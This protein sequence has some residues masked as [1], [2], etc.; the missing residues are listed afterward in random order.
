[1]ATPKVTVTSYE[2]W[3]S[4]YGFQESPDYNLKAAFEAGLDPEM[5][6]GDGKFHLSDRF[7]LPTHPTY[8]TDSD[9]SRSKGAPPAGRWE[10]S[11]EK[12][13]TFYASPQNIKNLGGEKQYLAWWEKNEPGVKLVLPQQPSLRQLPVLPRLTR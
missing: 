13:W 3:K 10:G 7:K 5:N 2:D 4:K 12:G 9:Y 11:E 8:S 6:S 1:V